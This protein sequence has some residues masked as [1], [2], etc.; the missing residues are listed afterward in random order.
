LRRKA[1][2]IVEPQDDWISF[3]LEDVL[4]EMAAN[5]T[6]ALDDSEA[7]GG[8]GSLRRDVPAYRLWRQSAVRDLG[9]SCLVNVLDDEG[10]SE[11]LFA[12]GFLN[13]YAYEII[14]RSPWWS[15]AEYGEEGGGRIGVL[16][17]NESRRYPT[18]QE[19]ILRGEIA[20]PDGRGWLQL[21]LPVQ[22]LRISTLSSRLSMA[23]DAVGNGYRPR[24]E[25]D[26][27]LLLL[28]GNH[29]R[30]LDAGF[31]DLPDAAGDSVVAA[32]RD[33]Q[34]ERAVIDIEGQ[35]WLCLW[36]SLPIAFG[37]T[38]G[39][40]FL[41]GLQERGTVA[42]LLDVG[43]LLLLDLVLLSVWIVLRL[44]VLRRWRWLPGFQGRLL[45]GYLGIGLVLLAIAGSLADRETFQR[46]DREAR[47]RT[48]DGLVTALGQLRGLLAEQ[49]R[50][51][52]AS[53]YLAD[54]LDGHIAGERPLGPI[55][56]RQG[57]VFDPTGRLI[58]DETLSDLD[59]A[60]AAQLL[61]AAREAPL[62]V[63][64]QLDGLYLGVLIPID[65][66]S[67][68]DPPGSAGAFFYRQLIDAQM[69]PSLADVVGGEVTLRVDGE[70]VDASHP[71]RV[72][73]GES[74][75]LA[76]PSFM[77]WLKT[78]PTQPRLQARASGL[79]FTGGVALPALTLDETGRLQRR[80]MPAVL[81][82][83]FPDRE[84]DYGAQR[85]R[86]GLFL[87][88]LIT[89]LILTAF[90]MAMVLTW[91][92]F[93]PLRVL[94]GA[95]RQL[96]AG[97]FEAP[98]PPEGNDE[99]G[100]L[101]TGFQAMRDQI[102]TAREELEA[103]E[104][105]LRVVLER[106]PVGVLVWDPQGMVVASNPA[107]GQ[108]LHR[109]YPGL[110][111][112]HDES[113]AF[114]EW[115]GQLQDDLTQHIRGGEGGELRSPDGRR[116]LRVGQAPLELGAG[117]PHRLVVCED[118]TEFLAAQKLALNAELARQVAHEIKNPLTPIQLSV[119]LLQ[120]A[121]EDQHPRLDSIVRD[122]VDRILEQVTLLRTIAGEFSLLG[123][124]GELECSVIDLPALVRDVAAGYCTQELDRGPQVDVADQD[125]PDVWAHQD[126]LLKVLGNL[127]QNS[128]DAAADPESLVVTVSWQVEPASVTLVWADNGSGIAADVAGRLFDPYFSTKSK[129]TGLGLAI[130]RN[131]ADKMGGAITLANRDPGPG[132]VATLALPRADTID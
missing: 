17:Q 103:R 5:D 54:L 79:A 32:L 131:L 83:E 7:S 56:V 109:F 23:Q 63:M 111:L 115:S 117:E 53:D 62:V 55:P 30:W 119:Q 10:T 29:E 67:M 101:S 22:S 4:G 14:E 66:S 132:A 15:L 120:Q 61:V 35:S 112:G 126:S 48:R 98:L 20:R 104:R 72:F 69:L 34:Q 47:A 12:T 86:M 18:G 122:A 57:M 91:N 43:R 19:R 81:S 92:I 13:D 97:D 44:L 102:H 45:L 21:E 52:A 88:G 6:H 87:T 105:F 28:R 42:V 49:A 71:G 65:L 8:R 106:V 84:R 82:V 99:V 46:I 39:E 129:G 58:L 130:C 128:L 24:L 3:L 93:V 85:R 9:L 26:R 41:L 123:R 110:E 70:V 37:T 38:A 89:L 78:H 114:Q 1:D 127:M 68:L 124:P 51:L 59:T 107:A 95:T 100:R 125:V 77:T 74:P 25:V 27:P 40:G 11:S 73:S 64:Q 75:L 113:Q 16:L 90:G 33:G 50:A 116:T 2:Q 118:L 108:I 121:Y 76:D 96:A 36:A 94:L 31:G 60:E 80:I